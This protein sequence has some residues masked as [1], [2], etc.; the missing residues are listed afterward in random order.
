MV[1]WSPTAPVL[2]FHWDAGTKENKEP[3]VGPDQAQRQ[4]GANKGQR[5]FSEANGYFFY[6]FVRKD[7]FGKNQLYIFGG[8]RLYQAN[9]A[10]FIPGEPGYSPHWNVNVVHTVA[11]VTAGDILASPYSSSHFDEEGVLFDDARDVLAA[12]DAGLVYLDHPGVVVLCPIV[13]EE[14]AEAPG[15]TQLSENFPSFDLN[16]GF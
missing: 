2:E 7:L 16:A 6:K 9:I 8:D 3:G 1:E 14:G 13:S 5:I 11:G 15:N 4:L 12:V 10:L